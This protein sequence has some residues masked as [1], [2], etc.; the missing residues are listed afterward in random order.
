MQLQ[1][2]Y[3]STLL[4]TPIGHQ[5]WSLICGLIELYI[6][7]LSK[8]K[9]NPPFLIHKNERA[10]RTRDALAP[11]HCHFAANHQAPKKKVNF[12]EFSKFFRIFFCLKFFSFKENFQVKNF[13]VKNF[14]VK[15]ILGQFSGLKFPEH[16]KS[17]ITSNCQP[18]RMRW[19]KMP[20]SYRIPYP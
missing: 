7:K 10:R 3:F 15:R 9:V 6:K 20:Y 8:K 18:S 4:V 2:V 1:L 13:Q 14:K 5:D 17:K 16:K 19:L 12:F 11:I